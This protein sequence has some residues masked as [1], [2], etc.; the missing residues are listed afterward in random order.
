MSNSGKIW[1]NDGKTSI[2][3]YPDQIPDGYVKGRLT[4]WQ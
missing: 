4:P 2:R 3:V 1:V